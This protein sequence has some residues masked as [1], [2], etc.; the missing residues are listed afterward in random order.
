MKKLYFCKLCLIV[1]GALSAIFTQETVWAYEHKYPRVFD[2]E[3]QAS[4]LS[5]YHQ[6]DKIRVSIGAEKILV[7][8]LSASKPYVKEYD[9]HSFEVDGFE[10]L[11]GK[12]VGVSGRISLSENTLSIENGTLFV[13]LKGQTV[14]RDNYNFRPSEGASSLEER[15]AFWIKYQCSEK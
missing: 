5:I 6:D 14:I 1:F 12:I 15:G 11:V 4:P 2:C 13:D 9:L 3:G 10:F 8:H 7:N